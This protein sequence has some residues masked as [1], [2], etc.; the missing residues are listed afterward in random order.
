[1]N[2]IDSSGWLE[3]FADADNADFF[4]EA[5][6]DTDNLIVPTISL[7]EVF[8]R[9][10]QQRDENAALQAVAHMR[11]GQVIPLDAEIALS[12]AKL[13]TQNKLPLADSVMLATSRRHK[14]ILWTQDS[15]FEGLENVRYIAK[16]PTV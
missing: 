9:I 5:I 6:T 16:T 3:F 13:G 8:K 10:L 1:M 15:D 2:V 11:Q 7:L 14:A 12:A 4:A